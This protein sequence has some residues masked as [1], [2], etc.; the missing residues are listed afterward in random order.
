MNQNKYLSYVNLYKEKKPVIIYKVDEHY[1]Y[2]D[3]TTEHMDKGELKNKINKF[4]SG[5]IV[6]DCP[7]CFGCMTEHKDIK[8]CHELFMKDAT[9]IIHYTDGKINFFI[10][11]KTTNTA[12]KLFFD[13]NKDLYKELE[14]VG[15]EEAQWLENATMGAFTYAKKGYEGK[16][17]KYDFNSRYPSIMNSSMSFPIKKGSFETIDKIE[18]NIQYGIYRCVIQGKHPCFKYNHLHYY[19]HTDIDLAKKLGLSVGL[20]HD[21]KPNFLSY[22]SNTNTRKQG[23][24]MFKE[25]VEYLYNLRLK[26]PT[27]KHIFKQLLNCL[28]GVLVKKHTKKIK[29][30][31]DGEDFEIFDF[32]QIESIEPNADCSKVIF[33]IVN[34][35]HMY[36]GAIPR[37]KPFLIS[38]GRKKICETISPFF[39]DVLHVHTD[40][41][42]LPYKN[43]KLK[44]GSNIGDLKYEGEINLFIKN[45]NDY[46]K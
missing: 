34:T 32:S 17:H 5:F 21:E 20:I 23:R 41:F 27:K 10:T 36:K 45:I 28:W 24:I 33:E 46:K 7:L 8:E 18:S 3:G 29:T 12:I 9:D 2:Y 30:C 37:L 22:P 43:E 6:V 44:T 14:E 25:Y 16:A 19:T 26:Y 39:D 35:K 15:Y 40:G 42:C 11:G 31:S 4:D 13:M 1:H 38:Q